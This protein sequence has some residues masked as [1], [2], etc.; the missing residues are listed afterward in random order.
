[1]KKCKIHNLEYEGFACPKCN[2]I[3]KIKS[4]YDA[5]LEIKEKPNELITKLSYK[6]ALGGYTLEAIQ[7]ALSDEKDL[8]VFIEE[9]FS[10]E[11]MDYFDFYSVGTFLR[12]KMDSIM[13]ILKKNENIKEEMTGKERII[14][15]FK[16]ENFE[17]KE[18]IYESWKWLNKNAVHNESFL[19]ISES[20][21][22]NN[23]IRLKQIYEF[24]KPILIKYD[25]L[26]I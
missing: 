25:K 18:K 14:F 8:Y 23:I 17:I 5:I 20:E 3:L 12:I 16:Y 24:L 6:I 10:R 13:K 1:M 21:M 22:E 7:K 9:R 11:Y 26:T 2:E 4:K 15:Y 19:N